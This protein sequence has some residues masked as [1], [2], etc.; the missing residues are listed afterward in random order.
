MGSDVAMKSP[1]QRRRRTQEERTTET[2]SRL[3]E[4][5]LSALMEEGYAR[6]TTSSIADRA[7]VSRGALSHH[8]A[9]KE[10]LVVEAVEHLLNQ[11]TADIRAMADDVTAGRLSLDTFLDRSWAMFSGRLFYVTLEHVAEARHNDKLRARMIPVV[12][13]FHRALDEIW[14]GYFASAGLSDVE[15]ETTLNATLCLLRG[16]GLQTVLRDDPAYY[17]RLLSWWKAELRML[18]EPTKQPLHPH[19]NMV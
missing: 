2:R 19:I 4:A 1:P 8:Y 12:R 11:A 17:E 9:S 15:L 7:R 3:L 16:M 5:T 6:T 10:D 14:R 18:L 13:E